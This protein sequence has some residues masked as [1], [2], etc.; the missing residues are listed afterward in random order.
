MGIDFDVKT[1][2]N[3]KVREKE[4]QTRKE[5]MPENKN[6]KLQYHKTMPTP[7]TQPQENHPQTCRIGSPTTSS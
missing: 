3:H 7:Q 5:G 4:N 1:H 6:K 2:K